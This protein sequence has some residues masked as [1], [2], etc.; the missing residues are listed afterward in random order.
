MESV[1][2][3]R[4]LLLTL[5]QTLAHAGKQAAIALLGLWEMKT[6]EAFQPAAQKARRGSRRALGCGNGSGLGDGSHNTSAGNT[7]SEQRPDYK[8]QGH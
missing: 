3:R 8:I 4:S 6:Y 7:E 5:G 2:A 1:K